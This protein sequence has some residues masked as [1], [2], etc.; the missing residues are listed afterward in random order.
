MLLLMADAAGS[1]VTRHAAP[2][3]PSRQAGLAGGCRARRSLLA[4]GIRPLASITCDD[5]PRRR[6][7][8]LL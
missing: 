1:S 6:R 8:P 2:D 7:A 4:G 5:T 3:R